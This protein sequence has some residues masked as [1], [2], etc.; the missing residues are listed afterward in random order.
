MNMKL[1]FGILVCLAPTVQAGEVSAQ[2]LKFDE[3]RE[4]C[5]SP[6]RFHNQTAPTNIQI[7]CAEIRTKWV[8]M[9]FKDANKQQQQSARAQTVRLVMSSLLSDKYAVDV[10]TDR[11]PSEDQVFPCAAFKEIKETVETARAVTCADLLSFKGSATDF[12]ATTTGSLRQAN[13]SSVLTQ[14]LGRVINMCSKGASE[15]DSEL[16]E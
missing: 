5:M 12:C 9:E 4:A 11:L 10:V 2:H 16:N 7:S 3:I 6:A 8:P 1:I 14:D 13:A 15:V